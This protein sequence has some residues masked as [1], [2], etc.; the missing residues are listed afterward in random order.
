MER[1]P[2]RTAKEAALQGAQADKPPFNREADRRH[3][4]ASAI[5]RAGEFAGQNDQANEAADE[6]QL[7]PAMSDEPRAQRIPSG[8]QTPPPTTT[9]W[10]TSIDS[11]STDDL[12][13]A[14]IILADQAASRGFAMPPATPDDDRLPPLGSSFDALQSVSSTL[15]DSAQN[16]SFASPPPWAEFAQFVGR[17][18]SAIMA[19]DAAPFEMPVKL[20]PIPNS[21]FDASAFEKF[22]PPS[23]GAIWPPGFDD[24]VHRIGPTDPRSI[25]KLPYNLADEPAGSRIQLLSSGAAP[26][27]ASLA[28]DGYTSITYLP[29]GQSV[30]SS[31]GDSAPREKRRFEF[32]LSIAEV[33]RDSVL[34]FTAMEP[35]FIK[36]VDQMGEQDRHDAFARAASRRACL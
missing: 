27:G 21:Q 3:V 20:P 22:A 18:I 11:P 24:L 31:N 13:L 7:D 34:T 16:D 30:P 9:D 12:S 6:I 36:L 1:N 2:P 35:A 17:S 15:D 19:P 4:I 14:D 8:L 32:E 29:F 28:G 25:V 26:A 10:S 5:R 23:P 33:E